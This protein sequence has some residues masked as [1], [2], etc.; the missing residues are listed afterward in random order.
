VDVDFDT[1]KA[2][3]NLRKHRVSFEEAAT[4]LYDPPA[5]YREDPDAAG[6]NRWVLVGLSSSLRMLTVVY[7]VRGERIRIVSA[8]KSSRGEEQDHAKGL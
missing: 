6:E 1:R 7:T 4:A 2:R 5:L 8:R 3:A